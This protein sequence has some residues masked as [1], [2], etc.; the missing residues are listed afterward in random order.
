MY[1]IAHVVYVKNSSSNGISDVVPQY[2]QY[3][4][5]FLDVIMV[6]IA[7]KKK[8]ECVKN[9]DLVILHGM[10][11]LSMLNFYK[12]NVDGKIPYI[13]VP[14]G[15]LNKISQGKS[16]IRK[17]IANHTLFK[18]YFQNAKNAILAWKNRT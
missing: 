17:I 16:K 3:Q 1:K 6:N 8:F 4:S 12:K 18:K 9:V 13:V 2:V 11:N 7:D 15:G 5:N 14:H 10:Y